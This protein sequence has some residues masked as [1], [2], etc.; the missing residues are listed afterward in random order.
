VNIPLKRPYGKRE[1]V[2]R[3]VIDWHRRTW[4]IVVSPRRIQDSW[5]GYRR[6]LIR[7]RQCRC[8]ATATDQTP[9]QRRPCR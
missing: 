2:K 4:G 3:V 5:E 6:F 7:S 8:A 1:W 9:R